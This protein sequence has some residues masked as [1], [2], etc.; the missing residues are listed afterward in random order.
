MKSVCIFGFA[1]VL[2]LT[3][4]CSSHQDRTYKAQEDVHSEKLKLVDE[5]KKCRETAGTD[6]EKV[7]SCDRYLGA[8]DA[9]K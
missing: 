2:G 3:L 6:N 5:Y 4:A 7:K 8:E 9:P 1:F